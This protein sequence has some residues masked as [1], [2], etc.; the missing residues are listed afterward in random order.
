MLS[1]ARIVISCRTV[2]RGTDGSTSLWT[3]PRTSSKFELRRQM[4]PSN[5]VRAIR[6]Q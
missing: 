4:P 6:R 1:S 5:V 3:G 2:R